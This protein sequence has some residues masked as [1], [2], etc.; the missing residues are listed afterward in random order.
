MKTYKLTVAT[1]NGNVFEDEVVMLTVRGVAGELA[2]M[3]GHIPFVTAIKPS[4]CKIELENGDERF[5]H[6]EGGLL[7]VSNESVTLL[8]GSFCWVD[9]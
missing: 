1:P 3:A 4:D 6:V 2:V 9:K 8:A 5:G 7:T